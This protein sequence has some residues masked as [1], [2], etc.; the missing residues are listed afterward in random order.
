M[1]I[2]VWTWARAGCLTCPLQS[3]SLGVQGRVLWQAQLTGKRYGATCT[4]H[5]WIR[6][7]L[8]AVGPTHGC[9]GSLWCLCENLLEKGQKAQMEKN[10]GEEAQGSCPA[11][12]EAGE[13]EEAVLLA[14]AGMA[15][16]YGDD[17]AGADTRVA[18][19]R[20]PGAIAGGCFL[21]ELLAVEGPCWSRGRVSVNPQSSL[22]CC[23]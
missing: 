7:G 11:S 14:G 5:S 17:R 22:N 21:K 20:G 18:A 8:M 9:Q 13:G 4:R 19:C 6:S 12:M 3:G 1:L 2:F 23:G 16:Q 15:L 10:V